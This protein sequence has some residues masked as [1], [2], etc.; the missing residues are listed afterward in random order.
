MDGGPTGQPIQFAT[1]GQQVYHK[2]T[3]DSETQ[4]TFCAVVHSCTV[5]DG[6]GDTVQILNAEGCALDK[7]LLNNLEYPTDLMAGQEAHVYKYADRSTLFYQCQISITIKE[8]NKECSRPQCAEPTGF[9]AV[10]LANSSSSLAPVP[11]SARAP[12]QLRLLKKR[13]VDYDNTLDVR[14]EINALD[15]S[16]RVSFIIYT[17]L[18]NLI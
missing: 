16:D 3:C 10:K 9:N 1:I 7:F 5:D 13:E 15:I 2:W 14:A 6:K 4:N 11:A 12:A 17:K 18:L 8:P